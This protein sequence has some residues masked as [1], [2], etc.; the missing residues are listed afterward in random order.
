[1]MR[2]VFI[3]FCFEIKTNTS[4]NY[5]F[6]VFFQLYLSYHYNM[7]EIVIQFLTDARSGSWLKS[8]IIPL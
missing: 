7:K 3:M 4:F 5:R 6:P 1:M 2:P 8:F